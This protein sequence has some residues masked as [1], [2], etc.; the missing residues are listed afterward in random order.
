MDLLR[1]LKKTVEGSYVD[2]QP[3]HI[4]DRRNSA[5]KVFTHHQLQTMSPAVR[6]E[7]FRN[8][9]IIETGRPTDNVKFDKEGLERMGCLT[10]VISVQGLPFDI[11]R[12]RLTNFLSNRSVH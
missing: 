8:K 7:W 12:K 2:G 9:H 6:Q 3:L 10:S 1:A 5:I 4:A 11:W